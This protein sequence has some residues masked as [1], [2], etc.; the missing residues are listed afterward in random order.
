MSNEY[1]Y[2]IRYNNKFP[3]ENFQFDLRDT[4]VKVENG[5]NVTFINAACFDTEEDAEAKAV[6]LALTENI[7]KVVRFRFVSDEEAKKEKPARPA[8]THS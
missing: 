7:Y 8:P 6:Q 2:T 3:N 4:K 5:D 1:K